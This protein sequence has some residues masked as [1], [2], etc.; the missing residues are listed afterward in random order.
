M[1]MGIPVITNSGVGDVKEIVEKYNAGYVLN[2]FSL[3][4][5]VKVIDDICGNRIS[6]DP[7]KIRH[8]ANDFY[9]LEKTLEVYKQVYQSILSNYA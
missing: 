9:D 2:D 8:G 5:M 3:P 6:F 7:E 4:S 1:A